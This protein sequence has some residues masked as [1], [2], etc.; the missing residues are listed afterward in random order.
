[1]LLDQKIAL[2]ALRWSLL[3]SPNSQ[4]RRAGRLRFSS[5]AFGRNLAM[6][7]ISSK[8][9]GWRRAL[10]PRRSLAE[11]LPQAGHTTGSNQR[12]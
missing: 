10:A 3:P 1:M 7:H 11:P 6:S 9:P 2:Q 4:R 8:M 12:A 5:T